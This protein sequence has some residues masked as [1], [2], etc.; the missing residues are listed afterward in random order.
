M[1]DSACCMKHRWITKRHLNSDYVI[2]DIEEPEARQDPQYNRRGS[3]V[4]VLEAV[5]PG[6][7]RTAE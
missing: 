1:H 5:F 3:S 6:A 2:Y 7:R 4:E